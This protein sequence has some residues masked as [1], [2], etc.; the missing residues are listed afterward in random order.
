MNR[1]G[2]TLIELL[3]VMVLIAILSVAMML[4]SE[5][6]ANTARATQIINDLNTWK[7]AALAYWAD[8]Q[9]EITA[10][11][12]YTFN[13]KEDEVRK[14]IGVDAQFFEDM[15]TSNVQF[16]TFQTKDGS[17]YIWHNMGF[18]VG[19]NKNGKATGVVEKL[20]GRAHTAGLLQGA[21]KIDDNKSKT[22]SQT[23]NYYYE[24]NDNS[25]WSS[26]C[27]VMKVR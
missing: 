20:I 23:D 18:G 24:G 13:D 2:F 10:N 22:T 3:I 4:S 16:K 25:G 11:L 15:K 26:R 6:V 27:I 12:N 1:K 8:N 9:D 5:Q 17:W 14:Y 19:N 21:S 7:K